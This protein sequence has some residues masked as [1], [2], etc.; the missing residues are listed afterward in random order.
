MEKVKLVI[1]GLIVGNWLMGIGR[2]L[3]PARIAGRYAVVAE[4]VV[5]PDLKTIV[6][7][8]DT[9]QEARGAYNAVE[10]SEYFLGGIYDRMEKDNARFLDGEFEPITRWEDLLPEDKADLRRARELCAGR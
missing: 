8:F 7:W 3:V 6:G 1:Y 4:S 10:D 5:I 9:V 2:R